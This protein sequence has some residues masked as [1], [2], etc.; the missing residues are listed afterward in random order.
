[1]GYTG[2]LG[3]GSSFDVTGAIAR[4]GA[5]NNRDLDGDGTD[6]GIDSG[7]PMLQARAGVSDVFDERVSA[8][9][10]GHFGWEDVDLGVGG[11]D[12]FTSSGIGADLQVRLTDRFSFSGEVWT[13]ENLDD[14]RGGVGQGIDT[15]RGEEIGATGGWGE[16]RYQAFDFYTPAVGVRNDSPHRR[17]RSA[18]LIS[19]RKSSPR[20]FSSTLVWSSSGS[21]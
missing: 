11:E 16:L 10:W 15:T 8:G 17:P 12:D 18:A 9:V 13:G 4:L 5:I 19:S 3:E 14:I 20:C 7:L 1:M 6:D 21:S 2:D